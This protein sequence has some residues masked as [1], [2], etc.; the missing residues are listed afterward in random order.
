MY[1]IIDHSIWLLAARQDKCEVLVDCYYVSAFRQTVTDCFSMYTGYWRIYCMLAQQESHRN[2]LHR[3]LW[4]NFKTSFWECAV[5]RKITLSTRGT[6][7]P[8]KLHVRPAK[9][10]YS[11]IKVFAGHSIC[12]Q[13]FNAPLSCG[14]WRFWSYCV[15]GRS[16][17]HGLCCVHMQFCRFCC[18]IA[19]LPPRR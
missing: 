16:G 14:Q 5:G 1:E 17:W 10:P 11:L 15:P 3:K 18:A 2:A 7:K 8:A 12:S 9:H 19:D 13:G 4:L 6:A